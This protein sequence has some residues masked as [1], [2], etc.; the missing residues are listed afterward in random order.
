MLNEFTYTEALRRFSALVNSKT[1]HSQRARS[2]IYSNFGLFG[3]SS[4]LNAL[5][6]VDYCRDRCNE[7]V[8]SSLIVEMKTDSKRVPS[9]K[10]TGFQ[11]SAFF[12]LF[13][14]SDCSLNSAI[15]MSWWHPMVHGM[16]SVH[17]YCCLLFFSS[18]STMWIAGADNIP[19]QTNQQNTE[20]FCRPSKLCPR[21]TGR[22]LYL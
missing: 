15:K 7:N 20:P 1:P 4:T 12:L 10:K 22:L 21:W 3:L 9:S 17:L 16:P 5:F 13:H 14:D 11:R 2:L 18:C 8:K 6:M 19:N